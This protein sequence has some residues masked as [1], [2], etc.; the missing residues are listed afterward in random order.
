MI[1]DED[2]LLFVNPPA[3]A[4]SATAAPAASA[5]SSTDAA[6]PAAVGGSSTVE[7]PS[8]DDEASPAALE[9]APR[10]PEALELRILR[11]M[12]KLFNLRIVDEE[13]GS[14]DSTKGP[15]MADK[16]RR[17]IIEELLSGLIQ[18]V[19]EGVIEDL[20]KSYEKK[21]SKL[22]GSSEIDVR[23]GETKRNR[24]DGDISSDKKSKKDKSDK[25]SKRD[26]KRDKKSKKSGAATRRGSDDNSGSDDGSDE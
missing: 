8:G 18:N 23:Q 21:L 5:T 15:A 17:R 16:L 2:D 12:T 10:L 14:V 26:K 25:K 11:L 3:P 24:T 19:I 9:K 4:P 13:D 22:D 6:T 20:A 1:H 7:D